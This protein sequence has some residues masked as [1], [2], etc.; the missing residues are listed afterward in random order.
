M[1]KIIIILMTLLFITGCSSKNKTKYY[2]FYY[3]AGSEVPHYQENID[4]VLN[5]LEDVESVRTFPIV[6]TLGQ[7]L[8]NAVN[9]IYSCYIDVTADGENLYHNDFCSTLITEEDTESFVQPPN[10]FPIMDYSQVT[11]GIYIQCKETDQGLIKAYLGIDTL[12]WLGI[13]PESVKNKHVIMEL[14]VYVPVLNNLNSDGYKEMENAYRVYPY[15]Y[16]FM[17]VRVQ[18]EIAGILENVN[19]YM[20]GPSIYF[21]IDDMDDLIKENEYEEIIPYAYI[22][23][24]TKQYQDIPK[25]Y[26]YDQMHFPSETTI[27]GW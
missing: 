19:Q 1:K 25:N 3:S 10:I 15:D 26:H 14:D 23:E 22:V 7:N 24:S 18:F 9:V 12:R 27:Y 4:E 11:K 16:I 5:T 21:L 6:A 8:K 13:V 17:P 2:E 20:G